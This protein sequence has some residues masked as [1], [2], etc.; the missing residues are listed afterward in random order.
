MQE[1]WKVYYNGNFGNRYRGRF[2]PGTEIK[3]EK[4]AF[5]GEEK[6]FVP[7]VY[8]CSKGLVIDFIIE[9]NLERVKDF[10][11]KYEDLEERES[12]LSREEQEKID[13][14]SPMELEFTAKITLNGRKLQEDRGCK[15]SWIPRELLK[16]RAGRQSGWRADFKTLWNGTVK[17]VP[18]LAA[19]LSVG[20]KKETQ[21]K[22]HEYGA[23]SSPRTIPGIH[24]K[25]GEIH[26][27][28]AFVHPVT[29]TE[30]TITIKDYSWQTINMEEKE[31]QWVYPAHC[32]VLEYQIE[33]K[34]G[35]W[36]VMVLDSREGDRPYLKNEDLKAPFSSGASAIA[37]IGGGTGSAKKWKRFAMHPLPYILSRKKK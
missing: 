23:F 31:T 17:S 25:T 22:D 28:V 14:E 27:K 18:N 7:S 9:V 32:A 2:R 5:W 12:R 8:M 26:Q 16:E 19:I 3:L 21:D 29:G 34:L 11:K 13:L 10:V 24:F 20:N 36:Q 35:P 15:M 1:E 6:V 4:W 37:M 30:H 33:P